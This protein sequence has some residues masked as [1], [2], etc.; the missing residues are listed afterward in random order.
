M[1][2]T[3]DTRWL[4]AFSSYDDTVRLAMYDAMFAY[5]EGKQP[6]LKPELML[7]FNIIKPWLDEELN[8]RNRLAERSKENGKK[9]GRPK[10]DQK[11]EIH[12]EEPK[13][14]IGFDKYYHLDEYKDR[15]DNLKKLDAWIKTNTPYIYAHM[16]PLKQKEYDKLESRFGIE[17]ICNKLL[18]I[19]NRKDLRKRYSNLYL[20][21]NNWLKN[22]YS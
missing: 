1:K 14:P 20:T 17:E 5:L 4:D 15:T 13:E 7:A 19:E 10:E 12:K 3:I 11:K 21:L 18:Q 2:L 9:G 8:K 6:R 16:K 22:G